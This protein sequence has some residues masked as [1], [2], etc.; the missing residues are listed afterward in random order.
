[1][2]ANTIGLIG[3]SVRLQVNRSRNSPAGNYVLHLHNIESS[4]SSAAGGAA[5]QPTCLK[6][7]RQEPPDHGDRR[8]AQPGIAPG[9]VDLIGA[10]VSAEEQVAWVDEIGR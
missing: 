2:S 10:D 9:G 1:M 3:D 8:D 6:R 5:L 4:S 7:S